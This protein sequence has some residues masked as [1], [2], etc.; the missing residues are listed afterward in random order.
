M[1]DRVESWVLAQLA[2]SGDGGLRAV[3]R[4]HCVPLHGRRSTSRHF[5]VELKPRPRSAPR[6]FLKLYGDARPD[7][8]VA[9]EG[10]ALSW[11]AERRFAG[12]AWRVPHVVAVDAERRALLLTFHEGETLTRRLHRSLAAARMRARSGAEAAVLARRVGEMLAVLQSLDPPPELARTRTE[13][14]RA[15][16]ADHLERRLT[17]LAGAGIDASKLRRAWDA[18]AG[19]S[20]TEGLTLQHSDFG[21]WNVLVAADG[22]LVLFDFHNFAVGHPAYDVAYMHE[23]LAGMCRLALMEPAAIARAQAALLAGYAAGGGELAADPFRAFRIMHVAYFAYPL[24]SRRR[25]LRL[26]AYGARSGRASA[27][28]WI[29]R[30]TER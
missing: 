16:Y 3:E 17:R 29:E 12:D 1:S 15:R 30:V 21:P 6:L 11:L 18:V 10:S 26:L 4:V 7:V 8:D 25:S 14:V 22:A 9:L 20:F 23:A 13:D 19:T 5:R 28:G 27:E 24:V 2:L